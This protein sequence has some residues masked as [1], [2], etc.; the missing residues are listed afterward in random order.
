MDIVSD[1]LQEVHAL[2][3]N[4]VEILDLLLEFRTYKKGI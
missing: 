4:K 3:N 1:T 2:Y